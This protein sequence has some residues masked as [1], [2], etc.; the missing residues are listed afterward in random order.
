MILM[1]HRDKNR[2]SQ[3]VPHK[4]NWRLG[5]TVLGSV[6]INKEEIPVIKSSLDVNV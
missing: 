4:S 5:C 1:L 6:V 3:N 2:Y